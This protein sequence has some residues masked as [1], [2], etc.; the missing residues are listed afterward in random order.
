MKIDTI[1]LM[2]IARELRIDIIKMLHKSKSGHTGGSLSAIDILTC[3][4]FSEMNISAD[5]PGNPKRD[6][7]VLSKGH[8]A[9]ALY[10]VLAHAGFFNK[11]VLDTLRKTDTILQGHP[12]MNLTPGVDM[13]TGSLGQGLSA[14]NGMALALRLDNS[15]A[16]VYAI[17]GD[18]EQQEGQIWEAAM[19]AAH[20]KLDNICAFV[21]KNGLQIDGKVEDVMNVGPLSD[22]WRA[23]GWHVIEI[24]GHNMDEILS[25]LEEARKTQGKPTAIIANT[26][27]GKGFTFCAGKVCYHGTPP[28][29]KDLEE[30]LKEINE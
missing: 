27:K 20:Y 14:A 15:P 8:A 25:A 28:S 12:D 26:T 9:P 13:S 10:A 16:R 11:D 2:E 22:K 29:D 21:D 24:D 1:E 5:D 3:L 17:M 30:G 23:F 4:Y 6:R 7:F 19:T 18:G